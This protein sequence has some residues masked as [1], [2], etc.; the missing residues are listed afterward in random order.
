MQS[1]EMSQALPAAT[2][3]APALVVYNPIQG[4]KTE[5]PQLP[6]V[7]VT[8]HQSATSASLMAGAV[9][10]AV[11]KMAGTVTTYTVSKGVELSGTVLAEGA[12]LIAGQTAKTTVQQ[13]ADAAAETIAA[14]G[15]TATNTLS[16]VTAAG[17]AAVAGATMMVGNVVGNLLYSTYKFLKPESAV[18][19]QAVPV[20]VNDKDEYEFIICDVKTS[21]VAATPAAEGATDPPEKSSR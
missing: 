19:Q 8:I 20:S 10:Y 16:M 9:T 21:A 1:K 15:Q 4:G 6:Q 14:A 18:D 3:T 17:A 2:A 5:V 11:T 13:K 7:W 12:K